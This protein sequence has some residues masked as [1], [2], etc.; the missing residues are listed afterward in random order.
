[1]AAPE[2]SITD[3]ADGS[4]FGSEPAGIGRGQRHQLFQFYPRQ[5]LT[6]ASASLTSLCARVPFPPAPPFSQAGNLRCILRYNSI[7]TRRGDEYDTNDGTC[8]TRN[9]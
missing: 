3:D 9:A 6:P 8:Y 7:H 2:L 5:H 4:D 1:M